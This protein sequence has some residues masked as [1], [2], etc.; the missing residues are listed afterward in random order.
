MLLDGNRT[1][2]QAVELIPGKPAGKTKALAVVIHNED[3][4]AVILRQFYHDMGS[5]RMLF[6]VV[7]CFTVNLENLAADAVGGV[8][9]SGFDHD[10]EGQGGFVAVALGET[11]HEVDEVGTLD[12][13]GPEVGDHAAELGGLVFYGV[14]EVA[15]AGF[16][17][18]RGG[19]D[20]AAE[21]IELDFD[22]EEGLENAVVEVAGDAAAFAF[23][24][25]GAKKA[26]EEDVF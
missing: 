6:Y 19:D 22:A 11:L 10:V 26:Q 16:G 18:V 3:D 13:Q 24:R 14:L 21:D 2:P 1:Q 5:L 4:A 8:E 20:F 12:T 25:A 17:L 23:D 9:V 7:E 15:E